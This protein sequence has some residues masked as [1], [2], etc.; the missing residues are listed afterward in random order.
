[1]KTLLL[2][3]NEIKALKELLYNGNPCCSGCVYPEMQN[4]KKVNCGS[5]AYTENIYNVQLK[6]ES[7]DDMKNINK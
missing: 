7:L 2:T 5:C 3:N 1:M 4:K 6:I